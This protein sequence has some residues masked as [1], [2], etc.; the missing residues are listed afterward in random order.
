M[1][2]R[3]FSFACRAGALVVA[4]VLALAGCH[5]ATP[6]ERNAIPI[7][8]K[9]T[10]ARGGLAAWRAVASMSLSGRLE[11]GKPR[12]PV[13][14]AMAYSQPENQAKLQARMAVLRG[15][16]TATVSAADKSVQLPY[17]MEMK[18][19]R[20][21]RVEVRF[22]GQTAIQVFDGTTGWKVR[23]FLG[24]HEVEPYNAEEMRIA[25]QQTELDGPLMDYAAKGSRLE[26]VGNEPV[27]GHDAYKLRITSDTGMSR[28]V[29]VDA[30]TFLD[31]MIDGT[32]TMDGKLR[33]VRTVFRDYK[34]VGGLMIPHVLETTVEGVKGSE[35][36]VIEHVTIN[37]KL[38]D[39]RFAKPE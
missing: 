30:Q 7:A 22:R 20:K 38:D 34:P 36:I 9:N 4:S 21:S 3:N 35:K 32:R 5:L 1:T 6:A 2:R 26:L 18:R 16:T 31:V 33:S 15:S 17:V 29:W 14:L 28:Q 25:A 39:A 10:V 27:E 37:P 23:P 24:R 19:P 8:E 11:A 13:K 12:D